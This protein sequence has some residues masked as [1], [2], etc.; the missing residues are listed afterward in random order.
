[1]EN[2]RLIKSGQDYLPT[3]ALAESPGLLH[4]SIANC[5]PRSLDLRLRGQ[6]TV[7][8]HVSTG[9]WCGVHRGRSSH[10]SLSSLSSII[11]SKDLSF[12]YDGNQKAHFSEKGFYVFTGN[13]LLYMYLLV[14]FKDRKALIEC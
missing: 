9:C 14:T 12:H 8:A 2:E 1:M 3:L 4:S 10:P 6:A 11:I 5:S 13:L 7:H